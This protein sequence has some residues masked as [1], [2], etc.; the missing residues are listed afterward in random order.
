MSVQDIPLNC[1]GMCWGMTQAQQL[2]STR[3]VSI[4]RV[5]PHPTDAALRLIIPYMHIIDLLPGVS[6]ITETFRHSTEQ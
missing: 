4:R 5:A 2:A 3:E 6:Y 1:T